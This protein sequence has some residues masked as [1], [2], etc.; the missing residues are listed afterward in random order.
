[1]FILS[2]WF[3]QV[4]SYLNAGGCVIILL[5]G[6]ST[7]MWTLIV[8]KLK[9]I[10]AYIRTEIPLNECLVYLKQK[11]D[12]PGWQGQLIKNFVSKRS[13]D[14]EIDRKLLDVLAGRY[15]LTIDRHIK[16]ILIL[17]G[18]APLLGLMGTVTGMIACFNVISLFGTGN[19]KALSLGISEALITT[20]IGLI[21]AIPGLLAGNF[22]RRRA[23]QAKARVKHFCNGLFELQTS[24]VEHRTSN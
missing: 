15:Y 13:F 21:V 11:K 24:N 8:V 2:D 12:I 23:E 7:W 3:E 10:Y 14:P 22:L 16:T 6:V 9:E 1:M 18:T 5:L 17:A 19:A 20:Q 4:V